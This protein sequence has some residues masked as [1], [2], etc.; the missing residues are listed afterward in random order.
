MFKMEN[1]NPINQ[2]GRAI[3][4]GTVNYNNTREAVQPKPT[5][6]K[7]VQQNYHAAK[8]TSGLSHN[9]TMKSLGNTWQYK[10]N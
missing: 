2:F 1:N 9:Q 10:T 4:S 3:S 5:W 7:F 6:P 8:N